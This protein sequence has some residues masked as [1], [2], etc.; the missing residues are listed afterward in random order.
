M[1]SRTRL[2]PRSREA[3]AWVLGTID[4]VRS[5]SLAG[6]P[7]V[8][9]AEPQDPARWSRSAVAHLD[10]SPALAGEARV[11]ALL[12]LA[13]QRP[14]PPV[15]YYDDDADL[16][17]VSRHRDRLA[18]GFRFVIPSADLVEDL[19]DKARFHPLAERL[20]LPVPRTVRCS[21]AALHDH[22]LRFPLI[23]KPVSRHGGAWS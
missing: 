18:R 2:P 5:L 11:D 17:F 21:S 1:A 9:I 19:V 16:L 13:A 20:G 14:E 10:V 3:E 22:G 6:I 12:A 15:L 7:V 23:V 8:V 4:L